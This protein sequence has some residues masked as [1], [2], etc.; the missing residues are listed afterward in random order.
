MPPLTAAS[1][2]EAHIALLGQQIGQLMDLND[3]HHDRLC[4]LSD[5]AYAVME[6]SASVE[7]LWKPGSPWLTREEERL[8]RNEILASSAKLLIA[9][10][11][12]HLLFCDEVDSHQ[13][14]L[15]LRLCAGLSVAAIEM[16]K[17]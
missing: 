3:A 17:I 14:S 15:C 8:L 11:R 9:R 4:L 10:D 12:S 5:I 2:L 6:A 13:Q 16:K 1:N 7:S